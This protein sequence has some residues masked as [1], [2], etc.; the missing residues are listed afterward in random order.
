MLKKKHLI[1]YV[2][3]K[4]VHRFAKEISPP[5]SILEDKGLK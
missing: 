5:S 3:R 2:I 4:K 1:Y